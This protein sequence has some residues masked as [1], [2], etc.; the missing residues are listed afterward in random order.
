M[1]ITGLVGGMSRVRWAVAETQ[2]VSRA[3]PSRTEPSSITMRMLTS[4]CPTGLRPLSTRHMRFMQ[5]VIA[6]TKPLPA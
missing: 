3:E 1:E 5:A 6:P 4:F 2:M